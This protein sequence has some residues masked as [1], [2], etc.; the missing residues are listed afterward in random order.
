[1]LIKERLHMRHYATLGRQQQYSVEHLLLRQS[2]FLTLTEGYKLG[3]ISIL[4][5]D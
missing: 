5:I 1:M 3:N 4:R 2:S